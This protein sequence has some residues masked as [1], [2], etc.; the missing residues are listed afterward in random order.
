MVPGLGFRVCARVCVFMGSPTNPPHSPYTTPQTS[1]HLGIIGPN[2][3]SLKGCE[4][5][6]GGYVYYEW[7]SVRVLLQGNKR[8]PN[9]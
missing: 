9:G 5:S 8:L 6:W 4:V 3:G 1:G 7:G 2:Y